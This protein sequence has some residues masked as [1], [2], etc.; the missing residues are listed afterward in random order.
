MKYQLS[1]TIDPTELNRFRKEVANSATRADSVICKLTN[2]SAPAHKEAV[3]EL[4]I[5][6]EQLR[7]ADEEL[8]AQVAQLEEAQD[9]IDEQRKKYEDLFQFAP[10]AYLITDLDGKV[11]EANE[12]AAA[13][14]NMPVKHLIKKPLALYVSEKSRQAFRNRMGQLGEHAGKEWHVKFQPRLGQEFLGTVKMGLVWGRDGL[15]GF[16]WIIRDTSGTPK[17]DV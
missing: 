15:E 14:F 2:R 11:L 8:R 12:V 4:M 3:Q 1:P 7:V 9:L 10:D 13:M 6:V 16:R 5:L 17:I